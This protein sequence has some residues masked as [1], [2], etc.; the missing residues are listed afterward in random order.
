MTKNITVFGASQ[1]QPGDLTYEQAFLLGKLLGQEGF[2]VLTGGYMGTMEAVSRGA[3]EAGGHTIGVTCEEIET[4]RKAK[5][6]P[7]VKEEWKKVTLKDRLHTLVEACDAALALPGG[8]GTLAEIAIYWSDLQVGILSPRPLILIGPGWRA[9]FETFIQTQATY[10]RPEYRP[11]VTFAN[12]VE[13]AVSLLVG[14]IH[15]SQ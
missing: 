8:I 9:T 15:Q 11:L 13:E 2:T 3:A 12:D 1:P 5:A 10:I 14:A 4:W 6:N 7:W